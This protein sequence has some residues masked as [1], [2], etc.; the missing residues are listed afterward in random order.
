M[1]L[2]LL[3]FSL[4]AIASAETVEIVADK[5]FTDEKKQ[6]TEFTGNV[7]ASKN[8]NKLVAKKVVIIFDKNREPLQYTATGDVEVDMTINENIYFGSSETMIYDPIKNQ[9]TF[10]TNAFFHEK[11]TNKKV[12]GDKI[13][14]NQ[15]TG[16]YEVESDGDE[17]VKF[18]FKVEK[19]SK[20]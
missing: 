19:N 7:V 14:V 15:T 18:I 13:F 2:L 3:L 8:S 4:A 16:R 9:Y 5:F 20:K 10:L 1:K 6:I 12:Y 11:V 17:P